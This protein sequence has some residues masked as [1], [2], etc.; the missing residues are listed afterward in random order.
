MTHVVRF[1]ARSSL[2]VV[3]LFAASV[4]PRPARGAVA[5]DPWSAT[6]VP[7]SLGGYLPAV[8]QGCM[9]VAAGPESRA[10]ATAL[11]AALRTLPASR[12]VMDDAAIG[13][14]AG[15]DDAA[16]VAKV[17]RLPVD[18]VIV[19]RVFAGAAG[20]AERAVVT[21]YG[22]DAVV[23]G[24]FTAL[25]GTPLEAKAGEA[26]VGSGVGAAASNTVSSVLNTHETKSAAEEQYDAS[27]ISL[28]EVVA[29]SGNNV[30]FRT[31]TFAP[32]QGKYRKPLSWPELYRILGLRDAEK[33]Y[34]DSQAG[35]TFVGV[36]SL[37]ATIGGVVLLIYGESISC[38]D[39]ADPA[40][41]SCTNAKDA[42]SGIGLLMMSVFPW[43]AIWGLGSTPGVQVSD[44]ELR[45]AVD[46]YNSGL[47]RRLGLPPIAGEDD[48][49]P[50]VARRVA[51]SSL[52][53]APLVL[54]SGGGFGLGWTF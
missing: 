38:P 2:L 16:I 21:M 4:V 30:A 7:A 33:R 31:G 34:H 8:R 39:Y 15:L 42:K 49:R 12:L 26:A 22:K 28:G 10:A 44:P 9:V 36:V 24:A 50:P 48:V 52:R 54:G 43:P 27:F 14:V 17:A 11:G 40:Y 32:S 20:E 6:F 45:Q 19:V 25:A 41:M 13:A 53:L 51:K 1:L 29:V 5:A 35:R 3:A 18:L 37:L 46:Q 47:R 23:A